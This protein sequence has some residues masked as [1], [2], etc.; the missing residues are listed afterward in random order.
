MPSPKE[1]KQMQNEK[2]APAA[3]ETPALDL[4]PVIS[5]IEKLGEKIE[6]RNIAPP[7]SEPVR[8]T[9]ENHGNQL[10]ERYN[11]LAHDKL[12]QAKL[13]KGLYPEV[14]KQLMI[15]AGCGDVVLSPENRFDLHRTEIRNANTVDAALAN[16]ILS[17]DFVTTMRTYTAPWLAFTRRV[18]MSP[19]SRRQTLEVPLVSTAGGMATNA[20]TYESG[21]STLA[22]IAVLTSE[23]SRSFHVT[24]PQTNLG[25][26]LAA[27]APTNAAVLGEGLSALFTATMT[28]ALFGA[29]VVIGAAANFDAADLPAILALGKNYTRTTLLLDGGHL[30]YLLPTSRESFAFGEPGA[31]GFDGG[32]YK[33]NLWTGGATDICGFVCGPDAIVSAWG[34]ADGLPAGEAIS[35]SNIEVNGFPFSVTTW[36][37]RAT[38]EVWSSFQ[39]VGGVKAGD[40]TQG[41]VLTT[42]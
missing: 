21:D 31:Y 4:S 35:Q 34:M 1:G 5:A 17:G 14:R 32:I 2:T 39:I 3:I 11:S 20:T 24:R 26:Q 27:L 18:E 9:I 22:P 10:V 23:Y 8:V 15:A 33:N 42:A 28:N 12:E 25:L 13:A 6:N 7:G 19:V 29:D 16:T 38:R 30:A 41:E 37:S 36:F 40:Q